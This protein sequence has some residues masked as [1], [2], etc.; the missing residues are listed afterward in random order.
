MQVLVLGGG[1]TGCCIGKLLCDEGHKVILLEQK[2]VLGGM[3]RTYYKDGFSYE[4]G[5]HILANHNCSQ[6]ATDF[7][8]SLVDT[9]PISVFVATNL[10]GQ[11]VSFPP[12][13]DDFNCFA[14]S[15][16]KQ[17]RTE[18]TKKPKQLDE[19]NF[20]TY[21]KS[22]L[23]PT[24]YG[25]Y[26]KRFTERFWADKASNLSAEWC[27]IRKMG[28]INTGERQFFKGTWCT[29]PKNGFNPI[30]EKLTQNFKVV[31]NKKIVN[32]AEATGSVFCKDGSKYEADLIISTISIDDLF[33]NVH[34]TLQYRGYEVE[35]EVLERP[36]YFPVTPFKESVRYSWEYFPDEETPFLRVTEPK[37]FGGACSDP[38]KTLIIKE[39]PTSKRHYPFHD[40]ANQRRFEDYLV[41]SLLFSKVISLGRLGL[42][43]YQT[44][45]STID[46]CFA[47]MKYIPHWASMGALARHEAYKDIRK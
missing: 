37:N 33:T 40:V 7:I 1:F 41:C 44:V 30:Y 35:A 24:V 17:I 45:D 42:Y 3:A 6:K 31:C 29:Y 36:H 15:V 25:L 38:N 21:L 12:H 28:E 2:D 10:F 5:P 39:Y 23:G 19:S 43:K 22:A 26:Y 14:K 47:A 11:R 8:E 20:E 4:Y 27:K 46:Q 16:Q 34:G 18:L 9:I 13:K 32:I